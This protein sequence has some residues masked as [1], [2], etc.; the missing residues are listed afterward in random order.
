MMPPTA[1]LWRLVGEGLALCY[2]AAPGYEARLTPHAALI[3]SGEPVADLNYAVI[4]REP[5]A[6]ERLREFGHLIQARNTPLYVLLTDAVSTP[7]APLAQS[8][9]LQRVG[10][11]PLMTYTPTHMP[12][13]SGDYHCERVESE[14][15]L[16]EAN[17]VAAS[18]FSLPVDAVQRAWGPIMLDGPGVDVFLARQHGQAISSVQTTRMGA[19]VGIWAM[20]T[21]AGHQQ[22]G[23]G[24]ALLNHV[25]GYHAGRGATR[26]FLCATAAGQPLSERGG[27]RTRAQ[28]IVWLA[29]QATHSESD[30]QGR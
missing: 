12:A 5:H 8:L 3:L 30:V 21:A 9:G 20:G 27:F 1:Y 23:A 24:R 29:G 10:E 17:R 18:A 16:Q 13:Q 25:I 22:K 26:F 6:E 28:A 14:P 7:L 2:R 19:T 15:A 11:M 4:D